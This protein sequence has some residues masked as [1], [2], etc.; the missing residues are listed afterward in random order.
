MLSLL[1][2]NPVTSQMLIVIDVLLVAILFY[3]IYMNIAHTRTLPVIKGAII[4]VS[5][6]V[7]SRFLNLITINFILGKISEILVIAIIIL[8]PSEIR[9]G[10]YNIGRTRLWG[11]LFQM[12]NKYSS[13]IIEAVKTLSAGRIGALIIIE[14]HDELDNIINSGIHIDSAIKAE[15]LVCLFYKNNPL[16][17]GAVIIRRDRVLSASCIIPNLTNRTNLPSRYGTRHRAAIGLSEQTDSFIIIV[18][19][20]TGDI[21]AAYN[22]EFFPKQTYT[23][24]E[25]LLLSLSEQKNAKESEKKK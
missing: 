21:A 4:L 22:S 10:L 23:N 15:L 24:L 3:Q 6:A 16:H 5:L 20:E 8:F 12:N 19:E 9:R 1:F 2:P 18:S 13:E 11:M 7:I 14:R 25:S 17:D